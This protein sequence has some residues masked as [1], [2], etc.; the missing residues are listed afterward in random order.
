MTFLTFMK[1]LPKK[2]SKLNKTCKM[3]KDLNSE[4]NFGIWN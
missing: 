2:Q 1:N 3:V 4:I